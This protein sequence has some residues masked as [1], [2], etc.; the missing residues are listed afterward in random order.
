MGVLNLLLPTRAGTRVYCI[1]SGRDWPSGA[2]D[3]GTIV[4]TVDSLSETTVRKLNFALLTWGQT[5]DPINAAAVSAYVYAY[6]SNFAHVNGAG[7]AAGAH[8]INGNSAVLAAYN[9][10]WNLAETAYAGPA[11]ASATV[12]IAMANTYDGSVTV[13]TNP[14]GASGTLSLTGAVVAGTHDST[15][16]V[17][18]GA[19]IPITGTPG[20]GAQSYSVQATAKFSIVAGAQQNLVVYSSGSQQRTIRGAFPGELAFSAS[21]ETEAISLTFSPIVQTRVASRFVDTGSHFVDGVTA[22]VATGSPAWRTLDSGEFAPIQATGTLYGPFAEHPDVS[23]EPPANAPIV[24]RESLTLAGPGDH[25]SPG[26]LTAE[27]PGFYTWVWSIDAG[28]QSDEVADMLPDAYRFADD[29]GLVAESHVVP[30]RVSATSQVT[31]SETGL[32]GEIGDQLSVS[33]REGDW[34]T[35]NGEP[36][37]AVFDGTA[38]FIPG[39]TAPG[40]SATVPASA[41][42]IGTSHVVATGPGIY[43]GTSTVRAPEAVSGY[44]TWVWALSSGSEFAPYFEP[45]SDQFG[46]PAETTRVEPPTV[47]TQAVPASAIG[48]EVHDTAMVGGTLPAEPPYLVFEAYFQESGSEPVCDTSTLVFESSSTPVTVTAEGSYDSPVTRFT[49][50][51]TYFW[52]E[53]LYSHDGQLIHRGECGLPEESTL[54]APGVVITQAVVNARPGAE[55]HDTAFV[56]GLVPQGATLVFEAFGQQGVT[57]G[58]LCD[59]STLAFR[60]REVAVTGPGR[61][62]S[63]ATDI[64]TPGTYYWV[65]TLLDRNGEPLHVGKC[66]VASETTTVQNVSLAATGTPLI[67]SIVAAT[68][69]LLLGGTAWGISLVRRRWAQSE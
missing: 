53:S 47:A 58:P 41:T 42:A 46:L 59:E 8:Y 11:H 32:G 26:V 24:G 30:M 50:Y 28:E 20:Q 61:Y 10:V 9:V 56:S 67:S 21:D 6:T 7:Y 1:D 13:T 31:V 17:K 54:V 51:G 44:V 36:L 18:D 15:V 40:P 37:A 57:D 52:I 60:S 27:S 34:L 4:S 62:Q 48:D 12:S 33:L 68:A 22:S 55:V 23:A 19:V 5:A 64:A 65:E 25:E 38:Y 14:A 35:K 16:G 43:S 49:E 2:T 3:G 45:W 63:P 29:F 69:L 39:D 66:G